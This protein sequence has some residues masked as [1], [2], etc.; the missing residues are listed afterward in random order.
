MTTP[1]IGHVR[2]VLM[3]SAF[4]E[5]FKIKIVCSQHNSSKR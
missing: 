2:Q 1:H 4:W 5:L 3:H